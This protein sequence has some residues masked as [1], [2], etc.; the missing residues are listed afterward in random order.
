M[1]WNRSCWNIFLNRTKKKS[2]FNSGSW[3]KKNDSKTDNNKVIIII[4]KKYL[5]NDIKNT[6]FWRIMNEIKRKK[7]LEIEIFISV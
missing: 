5:K 4:F 2:G 1:I 3:P 7:W 6:S